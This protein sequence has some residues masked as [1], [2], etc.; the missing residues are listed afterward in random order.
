MYVHSYQT[1]FIFN[2]SYQ[3]MLLQGYVICLQIFG[4]KIREPYYPLFFLRKCP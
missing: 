2:Q 4:R 3:A 1:M